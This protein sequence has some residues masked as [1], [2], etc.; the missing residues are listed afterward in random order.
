ME[1][2]TVELMAKELGSTKEGVYA[3]LRRGQLPQPLRIGDTPF[4]RLEDWREYCRQEAAKQ[5]ALVKPMSLD[6]T[7][8]IPA[9]KRRGRPRRS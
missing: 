9:P 8:I 2:I 4:W 7:E 1:I 3:R 6:A 5:G